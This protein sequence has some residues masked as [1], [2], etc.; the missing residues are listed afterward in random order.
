MKNAKGNVDKISAQFAEN[1]E[2]IFMEAEGQLTDFNSETEDGEIDTEDSRHESDS[3]RSED[4]EIE[5]RSVKSKVVATSRNNNA[6]IIPSA[7]DLSEAGGSKT[8]N[9]SDDKECKEELDVSCQMEWFWEKKK[10]F[11]EDSMNT[12]LNNFQEY[13]DKKFANFA[14]VMDLEKQL[15]E[16]KKKLDELKEKGMSHNISM[17]QK[18]I[19]SVDETGSVL[20]TLQKCCGKGKM[21]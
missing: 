18:E 4:E 3:E 7:K 15:K 17:N 2:V 6:S 12:S 8:Q 1:D 14:K 13:M 11:L 10:E 5:F 9:Q 19:N 16:N 20:N 21:I